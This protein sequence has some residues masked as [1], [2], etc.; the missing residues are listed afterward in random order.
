MGVNVQN[1]VARATR[2]PVFV[3]PW[4]AIHKASGIST[5]KS[6][7]ANTKVCQRTRPTV[8]YIHLPSSQR[9][10]QGSNLIIAYISIASIHSG[11]SRGFPQQFRWH[12]FC[13]VPSTWSVLHSLLDLP[14]NVSCRCRQQL[15]AK[16]K[17]L[18]AHCLCESSSIRLDSAP[19]DYHVL[20]SYNY[21]GRSVYSVR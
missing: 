14:L 11:R 3:H 8:N 21:Y 20:H 15:Y 17:G 5:W 1:S 7:I 6:N 16:Q 19:F 9:F 10:S 13:P 18:T 4:V 12:F 2:P